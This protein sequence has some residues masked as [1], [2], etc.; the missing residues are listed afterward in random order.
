VPSPDG[1]EKRPPSP[2]QAA[3][4]QYLLAHEQAIS[5]A[6]RNAIYEAYPDWRDEYGFDEEEAAEFMPDIDGL[7]QLKPLIG[8][9]SVHVLSVAKDGVGYVGFELGCT[10][11][12]E[13]GLGVMTHK[14]RVVKLGG[15]DTAF[16]DW[17][18]EADAKTQ[19][20]KPKGKGKKSS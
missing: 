8:L 17:I 1:T 2:K 13:H 20:E 9:S 10:W 4:Y 16:L 11:D 5:S 19:E 3:A 7:D 12:D 6:V 15:A 18:A 14:E